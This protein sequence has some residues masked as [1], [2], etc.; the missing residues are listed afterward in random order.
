MELINQ[1]IAKIPERHLAPLV[2]G[3]LYERTRLVLSKRGRTNPGLALLLQ[4]L[5][6]SIF[7]E[8]E[9]DTLELLPL[10]TLERAGPISINNTIIFIPAYLNKRTIGGWLWATKQLSLQTIY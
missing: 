1:I 2:L 9:L 10:H 7:T 8:E 4:G 3:T 6:I 5:D